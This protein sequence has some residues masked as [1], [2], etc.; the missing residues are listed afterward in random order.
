MTVDLINLT[1][2]NQV[3]AKRLS[4]RDTEKLVAAA[5]KPH[6]EKT[7]KRHEASRDI[8]RLEEELADKLG[9]KVSIKA[10][11]KGVGTL[12]ISF[13]GLDQLD[14]VLEKLRG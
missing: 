14:G 13:A 5:L 7:L 6:D 4:V 10:N 11:K 3:V 2:A 12:T 8:V 9:A 1:L